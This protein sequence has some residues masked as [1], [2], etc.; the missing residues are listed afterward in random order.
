MQ[1]WL[2]QLYAALDNLKIEQQYRE[3]KYYSKIDFISNDYLGIAKCNTLSALMRED[4]DKGVPLGST[5]SRLLSGNTAWHEDAESFF[6]MYFDCA[7]SLIMNS[8][9]DANVAVLSTLPNRNDIILY[10]E[11]V[12]AS[13]KEGMRLS[14]AE[15]YAVKHNDWNDLEKKLQKYRQNKS[16]S[17]I[18]YVFETVYS[19]DGDIP[20]VFE[21][22]KLAQKY[23]IILIAD[24]VHAFGVFGHEGQGILQHYNLHNFVPV[25]IMG[26]GKAAATS[27][28]VIAVQD[29][30]IQKY[31]INKA[32]SFIYTTA[33]SPFQVRVMQKSAELIKKSTYE[34]SK[35]HQNITLFQNLLLDFSICTPIIPIV[36]GSK[37]QAIFDAVQ[38]AG[39]DVGMVRSPTVPRGKERLRISVH[40]HNSDDEIKHLVEVIKGCLSASLI[41]E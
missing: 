26:F 7:A 10:D 13:I 31:L 4:L 41:A 21:L 33:V 1:Q 30:A 18:F 38:K 40:T 17:N 3:L 15:R 23:E 39:F 6:K 16:L 22:L 5:G 2:S 20:A 34:R 19:M 12:H 9:Y 24:E 25:R 11:K 8:A 29:V 28:A 35:L 14:F 37:L 36:T 27:G 32:R